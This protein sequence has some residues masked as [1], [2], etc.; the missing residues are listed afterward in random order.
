MEPCHYRF[1][2][3]AFCND[4]LKVSEIREYYSYSMTLF[5]QVFSIKQLASIVL[6]C[7]ISG[8][9]NGFQL[10]PPFFPCRSQANACDFFIAYLPPARRPRRTAYVR[11]PSDRRRR[12]PPPRPAADRPS[13]SYTSMW[14]IRSFRSAMH[15]EGYPMHGRILFIESRTLTL[16]LPAGIIMQERQSGQVGV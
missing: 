4:C 5:E 12:T 13:T 11:F 2:S 3:F 6:R 16:V 9:C 14:S 15:I 8:G 7:Y 10:H 1:F